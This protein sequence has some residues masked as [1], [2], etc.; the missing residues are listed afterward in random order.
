MATENSFAALAEI[1]S[2]QYTK[3]TG[4]F[5]LGELYVLFQITDSPSDLNIKTDLGLNSVVTFPGCPEQGGTSNI[6]LSTTYL[7]PRYSFTDQSG[8]VISYHSISVT[9]NQ[10]FDG[11]WH[12]AVNAGTG[13]LEIYQSPRA[14]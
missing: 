13:F 8:G 14:Q 6:T 11:S 7:R 5:D 2:S 10:W 3:Q 1:D 9:T 12:P 4:S